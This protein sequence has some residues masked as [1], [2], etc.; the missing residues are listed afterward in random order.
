VRTALQAS[1]TVCERASEGHPAKPE[2]MQK[3]RKQSQEVIENKG[4]QF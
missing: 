3:Q 2:K 4:S 1:G